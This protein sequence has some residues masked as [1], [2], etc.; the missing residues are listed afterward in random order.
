MRFEIKEKRKAFG[1]NMALEGKCWLGNSPIY[2][3]CLQPIASAELGR[4]DHAISFYWTK[5]SSW[6][7]SIWHLHFDI[8]LIWM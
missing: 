7:L 4:I 8:S 2:G 6:T 5:G 3:L 1:P